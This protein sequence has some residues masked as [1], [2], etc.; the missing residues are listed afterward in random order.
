MEFFILT[1]IDWGNE[2]YSWKGR[3]NVY[4][5]IGQLLTCIIFYSLDLLSS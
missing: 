4:Y 5:L 3:I 1:L 2:L